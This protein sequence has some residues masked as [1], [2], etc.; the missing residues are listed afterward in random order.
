MFRLLAWLIG[1]IL[2]TLIMGAF[3]LLTEIGNS[4]LLPSAQKILQYR[5]PQAKIELLI[6]RPD[7]ANISLLLSNDT[8]ALLSAKIDI[9]AGTAI[10]TWQIVSKDLTQLE[11]ITP[12][13]LAG[14]ATSEGS[15]DISPAQQHA[16]GKLML[17]LSQIDFKLNHAKNSALTLSA[18]GKL[19]L[20]EIA[21]LLAQP[22]F[23]T[24]HLQLMT[25]L[26]LNDFNDKN[27]LN[28]M[29]VSNITDGLLNA[30]ITQQKTGVE[31]PNYI[32][33]AA[34]VTTDVLNGKTLSQAL[35][36]SP[37]VIVNLANIRYNL[38]ENDILA[39]HQTLIHELSKLNF[40]TRTSLKGRLQVNGTLSYN[41]PTNH[42]VVE[43]NSQTLGGKVT[44]KLN[45]DQLNTQ[46]DDLQSSAIFAMLD[47]PIVFK[48]TVK[49][50]FVYD[51]SKQQGK[52][53]ATLNNGQ[54]LPNEFA[55]ALNNLTQFD[56]T[57]ESYEQTHT[58]GTINA[59]LIVANLDMRSRFTRIS[60]QA[61]RI[62]FNKQHIDTTLRATLKDVTIPIHLQGRLSSPQI[63]PEL[64]ADILSKQTIDKE[65]YKIVDTLKQQLNFPN[66]NH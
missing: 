61:A 51:L 11:S 26:T 19:Q 59:G 21:Q 23:A 34:N 42:L 18:Q 16:L 45:G 52:F 62:D 37:L 56:I 64:S 40:V 53:D 22:E 28:G 12:I 47:M 31:L 33:F 55:N 60:T 5:L 4:F 46:G 48:S 14:A 27:T 63:M 3:L 32:P 20:P 2:G 29:V 44:L 17:T 58:D 8:H 49:A 10:G 36:N 39:D 65:K 41:L 9:I 54:F 66:L 38:G 6:I 15:F 7:Q 57:Q 25:S 30:Q 35:L 43:A 50:A 24:G 13:P 1:L